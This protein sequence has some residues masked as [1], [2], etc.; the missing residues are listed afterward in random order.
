MD[1]HERDHL[2]SL[3]ALAEARWMSLLRAPCVLTPAEVQE[4]RDLHEIHSDRP[5]GP[6]MELLDS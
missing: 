6:D 3:A 5:E 4:L 1:M 2:L